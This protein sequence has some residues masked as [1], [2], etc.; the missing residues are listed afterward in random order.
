M[1]KENDLLLD[2]LRDNERFADL[3]NGSLFA[4]KQIITAC[5]LQEAGENYT[6]YQRENVSTT[7]TAAAAADSAK[8]ADVI[9]PQGST[10]AKRQKHSKRQ[11]Q[12]VTR[13]RDLKKRLGT[14]AELRI[15]AVEGQSYVDYAMPWRCMNYD[16]LEYGRQVKTI[17]QHNRKSRPYTDGN[18]LLSGFTRTDRIAPVYTVCLYHGADPWDGPRSLKDMVNPAHDPS[19]Q[20]LEQYFAII[21]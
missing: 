6:E 12:T 14:G 5:D 7:D 4:G 16:A 19:V 10:D 17:Q 3:F 18:E 2:Y 15:L 9:K 20:V 21:R 11:K 13:S 1:G 8:P